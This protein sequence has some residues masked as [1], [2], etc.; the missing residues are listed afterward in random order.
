MKEC[1]ELRAKKVSIVCPHCHYE[2]EWTCDPRGEKV[3]CDGCLQW[4]EV[5]Q[6]AD[7]EYY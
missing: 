6:D 1:T 4:Y 3:V 5:S 2:E 7:I